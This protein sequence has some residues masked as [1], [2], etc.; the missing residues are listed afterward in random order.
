MTAPALRA[1]QPVPPVRHGSLGAVS[2]GEL[3]RVEL[4]LTAAVAAQ[5]DKT[6]QD[7][8]LAKCRMS[9]TQIKAA[10]IL[11]CRW[12]KDHAPHS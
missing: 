2:L 4:N 3:S 1:G 7:H 8:A 6:L 9:I 12:W 10:D 11:Q 5:H